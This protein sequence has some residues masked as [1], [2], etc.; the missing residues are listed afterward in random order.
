MMEEPVL[1]MTQIAEC[2]ASDL[3][4]ALSL[5]SGETTLEVPTCAGVSGSHLPIAEDLLQALFVGESI[6]SLCSSITQSE[7]YD[8][9]ANCLMVGFRL[10][11]DDASALA[12]KLK[13][14]SSLYRDE[15]DESDDNREAEEVYE[16]L[17]SFADSLEELDLRFPELADH[18]MAN[19]IGG[20]YDYFDYGIKEDYSA[21]PE[22]RYLYWRSFTSKQLGGQLYVSSTAWIVPHDLDLTVVLR[23]YG[24]Y[25]E[26]VP[27][28][29]GAKKL[30]VPGLP[31]IVFSSKCVVPYPEGE[32]AH[33]QMCAQDIWKDP[34][35]SVVPGPVPEIT[36]VLI[37]DE[38][39]V[40]V[41]TDAQATYVLFPEPVRGSYV[42][43][44]EECLAALSATSDLFKNMIGISASI[45]CDW[46]RLDDEQFE[47]LCYDV[48]C[49]CGRYD[50]TSI[51]KMGKSR[52]RDGGRDIVVHG[53][54]RLGKL[55]TKWLVQCKLITDDGTLGAAKVSMSDAVDQYSAGGYC[56]MT[57][58]HI[59][60]TL[61]DKLDGIAQNRKIETDDWD[62]LKL[63]RFLAHH[64]HI[65]ARYFDG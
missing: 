19:H 2:T 5:P 15:G 31:D 53:R 56:V 27:Q 61:Y 43:A 32:I 3:E 21:Y 52:S 48:L 49:S 17:S 12:K 50:P 36:S 33:A 18:Y 39:D 16:A 26:C 4:A 54:E 63:E 25:S 37:S 45:C 14:L 20:H 60:A 57:S 44:V 23:R 40:L 38:E 7:H 9:G 47:Q 59:D 13:W 62:R 34:W 58:G 51:R 35:D 29:R 1:N 46:R 41:A 28:L 11:P 10:R 42:Q 64:P 65:R 6:A 55:P 22:R 24:G 30:S 8:E